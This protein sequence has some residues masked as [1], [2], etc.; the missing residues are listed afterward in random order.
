MRT[1]AS[2]RQPDLS[3]AQV[4]DPSLDVRK[5][6]VVAAQLQDPRNVPQL[7]LA[8]AT[9]LCPFELRDQR[10]FGRSDEDLRTQ[11]SGFDAASHLLDGKR[12]RRLGRGEVF[13]AILVGAQN[14]LEGGLGAVA[15]S[16]M[17]GDD[18]PSGHSRKINEVNER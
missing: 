17:S 3:E 12:P 6:E 2:H 7:K 13:D 14:V 5:V 8:A 18:L 16:E 11:Q 15:P 9:L 4:G 1:V 10:V